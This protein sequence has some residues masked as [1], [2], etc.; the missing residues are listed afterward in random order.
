MVAKEFAGFQH[1][2]EQEDGPHAGEGQAHDGG[3]EGA[4]GKEVQQKAGAE[5]GRDGGGGFAA[6]KVVGSQL[7]GVELGRRGGRSFGHSGSLIARSA[8]GA[9]TTR[10]ENQQNPS[11]PLA[12]RRAKSQP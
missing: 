2:E 6:R 11:Q 10:A 9:C 4:E 7:Q 12:A 8:G 1:A 3:G 5:G